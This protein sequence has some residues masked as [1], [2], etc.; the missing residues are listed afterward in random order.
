MKQTE[1]NN[2]YYK[3][4]KSLFLFSILLILLILTATFFPKNENKK[5][6]Q[7][8]TA[9]ICGWINTPAVYKLPVGSDLGSLIIQ[10]N[11]ITQNADIRNINLH[12]IIKQDSIYHIPSRKQNP[13]QNLLEIIEKSDTIPI[14]PIDKEKSISVLYVGFPTLYLLIN[15]FPDKQKIN[16]IYLPHSTRMLSNEY[17]LIDVFFTMGINPTID[18]LE[19]QLKRKIDYFFI[20]DRSSFIGMIDELGGLKLPLD[21]TFTSEYNLTEETLW[22][23]GF[24][25][26]EYMHFISPDTYHEKDRSGKISTLENLELETNNITSAFTIRQERQKKIISL[27]YSKFKSLIQK[28]NTRKIINLIES[29]N[30]NSNISIE[31]ALEILPMLKNNTKLQFGTLP[32]YYHSEGE[33]I[34]Y[35]PYDDKIAPKKEIEKLKIFNSVNKKTK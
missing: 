11:G 14:Q 8:T 31:F 15:Y 13:R 5:I 19:K 12:Q 17:R 4:K 30:Y 7:F 25:S 6:R 22:L 35:F 26:W 16:V 9:G 21:S 1:K 32:G 20:Q 23:D 24:L 10:G 29:F 28:N 18:I 27:L 3:R 34:L 2:L 33:S